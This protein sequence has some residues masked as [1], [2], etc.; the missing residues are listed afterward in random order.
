MHSQEFRNLLDQLHEAYYTIHEELHRAK[1]ENKLLNEELNK[2]RAVNNSLNARL[3]SMNTIKIL[4]MGSGWFIDGDLLMNLSLLKRL[5]YISPICN[6][7]MSKEGQIAFTCNEKIFLLRN[8]ETF[9]VQDRILA[10]DPRTM[11]TDL[12]DFNRKIF[13]FLGEDIVTYQ[14]SLVKRYKE[15][16]VDWSI[17]LDGVSC[18]RT[19]KDNVYV[20][21]VDGN[22]YV[23]DENGTFKETLKSEMPFD[24]FNVNNDQII[25][26]SETTISTGQDVEK[27]EKGPI[28]GYSII[29][30]TLFYVSDSFT[31][32]IADL[33][34]LE[35]IDTI[36]FKRPILSIASYKGYLVVSTQDRV[37]TILDYESKKTMRV[38][39][40]DNAVD[41][42]YNEKCFCYVDNNGGLNVWEAVC[43]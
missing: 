6:A 28:M 18:I 13:D 41:I 7:R 12:T 2:F 10:F 26:V 29:N 5:K 31:I 33:S 22:I 37:L 40:Q 14:D 23:Y 19:H 38:V 17:E 25:R 27:V 1:K 11:K 36:N 34:T 9:L 8:G 21:M 39:L 4:K 3:T 43:E 32:K 16:V 24:V 30:E 42:C 20:G 15:D 35:C